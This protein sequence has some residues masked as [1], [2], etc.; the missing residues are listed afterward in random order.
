MALRVST[1]LLPSHPK[2]LTPSKPELL[3]GKRPVIEEPKSMILGLSPT[4]VCMR[5]IDEKK[6]DSLLVVRPPTAL[7]AYV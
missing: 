7:R 2:L 1:A 6:F 4:P 3:S 5:A